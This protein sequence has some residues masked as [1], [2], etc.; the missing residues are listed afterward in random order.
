MILIKHLRLL[1]V[2]KK[3]EEW[4]IELQ[5]VTTSGTRSNK[6]RQRVTMSDNE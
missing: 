6:E 1:I 4:Y 3:A 5:L 2:Y